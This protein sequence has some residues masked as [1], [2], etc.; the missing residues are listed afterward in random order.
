M[1]YLLTYH[2]VDGD[3]CGTEHGFYDIETKRFYGVVFDN[4]EYGIGYY[5]IVSTTGAVYT[6]SFVFE[7]PDILNIIEMD[8]LFR[9]KYFEIE[10]EKYIFSKI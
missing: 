1:I 3:Y 7:L 2:R 4:D 5:M 9:E 10:L 6:K 8:I